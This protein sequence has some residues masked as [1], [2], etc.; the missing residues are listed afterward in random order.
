[1]T[2]IVELAIIFPLI[3]LFNLFLF[4]LVNITGKSVS[5]VLFYQLLLS[6]INVGCLLTV[7]ESSKTLNSMAFV[8]FIEIVTLSMPTAVYCKFSENVTQDLGAIE[9]AF[10]DCLWY[11]WPAKQQKLF[12]LPIMRAQRK[13]RMMG[14]GLIE[15]SLITFS[16][17]NK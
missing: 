5:S 14:L 6:A 2:T 3:I 10:S 13:Y 7:I 15:C 1:M 12:I 16:T 11:C 9:D 8:A 17:V 4:S